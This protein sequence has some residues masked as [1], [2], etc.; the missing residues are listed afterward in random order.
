M[1]PAADPGPAELITKPGDGER[2]LARTADLIV[3]RETRRR[4]GGTCPWYVNGR[5]LALDPRVL[6][7][8][9]PALAKLAHQT[10]ATHIGGEVASSLPL[11]GAAVAAA[12]ARGQ[13]LFGC[14]F[15][16]ALKP[17]GINAL[18]EGI[19]DR[20]AR[21]LL[22]DDVMGLGTVIMRCHRTL[23]ALGHETVAVSPLIS[24]DRSGMDTVSAAGLPAFS[25]LEV[26]PDAEVRLGSHFGTV[27]A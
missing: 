5:S 14:F 2:L 22:I 15:R 25:F 16:E 6:S 8:V 18:L 21:V 26:T 20:Q 19:G 9:G 17:T 7:I 13:E 27:P 3:H 12:G 24:R 11:M 23:T 1:A 10:G 4:S